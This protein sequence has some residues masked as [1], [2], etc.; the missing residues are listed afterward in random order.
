MAGRS[1]TVGVPAAIGLVLILVLALES[2]AGPAGALTPTSTT[3]PPDHLRLLGHV[4]V[5]GLSPDPVSGQSGHG[6]LVV[7]TDTG[8]AEIDTL[9]QTVVWNSPVAGFSSSGERV[10]TVTGGSILTAPPSTTG[11]TS[12]VSLDSSTGQ[13][14]WSMPGYISAESPPSA[15]M[16]G[17]ALVTVGSTGIEGLDPTTG[18]VLWNSGDRYPALTPFFP[19]ATDGQRVFAGDAAG[20]SS[21]WAYDTGRHT[22]AWHSRNH[23]GTLAALAV[24]RRVVVAV[25]EA[26]RQSEPSTVYAYDTRTGHQLWTARLPSSWDFVDQPAVVGTNVVVAAGGNGGSGDWLVSFGLSSG[27]EAWKVHN[28][29]SYTAVAP[30][31]VYASTPGGLIVYSSSTGKVLS[32]THEPIGAAGPLYLVG[33]RL[34]VIGNGAVYLFGSS[35]AVVASERGQPRP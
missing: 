30:G 10:V 16:A 4:T 25:V 2:M 31:R 17:H 20:S 8:V 29:G 34:A 32:T 14:R 3:G 11:D 5:A 19:I 33:D 26:S 21:V 6:L 7:P 13:T 9:S 24:G 28:Q 23:G 27:H 35:G 12:L 22:M 18:A 1:R 15:V